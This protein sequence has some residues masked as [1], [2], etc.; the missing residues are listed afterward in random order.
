MNRLFIAL[1]A[2][3]LSGMFT[4]GLSGCAGS[5][6]TTPADSGSGNAGSVQPT[7]L[8]DCVT[9]VGADRTQCRAK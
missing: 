7:A 1:A 4:A 6:A 2:C 9:A 5:A 8:E 3:I